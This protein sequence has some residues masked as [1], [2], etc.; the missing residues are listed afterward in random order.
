MSITFYDFIFFKRRGR[1]K[2]ILN[3]HSV[4]YILNHIWPKFDIWLDIWPKFDIWQKKVR[5]TILRYQVDR[6]VL[7]RLVELRRGQIP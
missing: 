6:N 5:H 4:S 3:T 2:L 1:I 7:T